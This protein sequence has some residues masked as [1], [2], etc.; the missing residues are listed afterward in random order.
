MSL[1]RYFALK[2]S[3]D[4]S[5]GRFEFRNGSDL[6]RVQERVNRVP[7]VQREVVIADRAFIAVS[8]IAYETIKKDITV[9]SS[10]DFGPIRVIAF[11][12]CHSRM[13]HALEGLTPAYFS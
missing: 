9:H 5:N 8:L 4:F 13:R 2:T 12:V 7:V 10:V 3:D 11:N 1:R 6:M